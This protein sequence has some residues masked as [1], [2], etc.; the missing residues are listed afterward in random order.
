MD[1]VMTFPAAIQEM[2]WRPFQAQSKGGFALSVF[3][4]LAMK[5]AIKH[6]N[7]AERPRGGNAHVGG[8]R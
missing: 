8:W 3:I 6:V 7:V 2:I 1:A 5:T 4:G